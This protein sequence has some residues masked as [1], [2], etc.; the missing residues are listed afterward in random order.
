MVSHIKLGTTD[1]VVDIQWGNVIFGI[2]FRGTKTNNNI[3][4]YQNYK[5]CMVNK[6]KYKS[7]TSV[8]CNQ[9]Q[10]LYTQHF[11]KMPRTLR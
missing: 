9:V 6:N 3:Q 4:C 5:P 8:Y 10:D 11:G 7:I 2:K 1:L